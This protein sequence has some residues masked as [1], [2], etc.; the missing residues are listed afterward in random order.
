M[1]NS[2]TR[3]SN[4]KNTGA[5]TTIIQCPPICVISTLF[6]VAQE[7]T[8]LRPNII[9][10]GPWALSKEVHGV[11]RRRIPSGWRHTKTPHHKA[12]SDGI[13]TKRNIWVDQIL[14]TA[15]SQI[16]DN[17]AHVDAHS[18]RLPESPQSKGLLF[19]SSSSMTDGK[20]NQLPKV[21]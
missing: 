9:Y 7:K 4:P 16:R 6:L 11:N 10:I 1:C 2:T 8:A 21:R 19:G 15:A 14:A 3:S 17:A 18:L 20:T 5:E 12:L 13:A